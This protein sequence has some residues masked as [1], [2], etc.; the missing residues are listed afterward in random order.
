MAGVKRKKDLALIK[1]LADYRFGKIGG[2]SNCTVQKYEDK[3]KDAIFYLP[4]GRASVVIT[5]HFVRDLSQTINYD[6]DEVF[7]R[8]GNNQGNIEE[9]IERFIA[10]L[11]APRY[12]KH[13]VNLSSG[14]SL[15]LDETVIPVG[16]GKTDAIMAIV[17][18]L[19]A[20]REFIAQ[21][22]IELQMTSDALLQEWY[23]DFEWHDA[24]ACMWKAAGLGIVGLLGL[25]LTVSASPVF[26]VVLLPALAGAGYFGWNSYKKQKEYRKKHPVKK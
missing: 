7:K 2:S 19:E 14:V 17:R 11:D 20:L 13:V 9:F 6:F 22:D 26:L 3:S 18:T 8:Y 16:D 12:K 1:Y 15:S 23:D 4:F 21:K 10:F 24:M 5:V 25:I